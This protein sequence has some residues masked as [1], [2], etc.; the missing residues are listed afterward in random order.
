MTLAY[1]YQHI[2]KI[3]LNHI[4]L[5]FLALHIFILSHIALKCINAYVL[6]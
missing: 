3:D 1:I 4:L 2:K 5:F 6:Y